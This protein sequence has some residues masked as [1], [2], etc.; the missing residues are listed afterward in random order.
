MF[1]F[2]SLSHLQTTILS[3]LITI[4]VCLKIGGTPYLW[5]CEIAESD[6]KR[7]GSPIS[8]FWETAHEGRPVHHAMNRFCWFVMD[9][10]FV[11]FFP[12]NHLHMGMGQIQG[13]FRDHYDVFGRDAPS[14][15]FLNVL[16]Q[17][18]PTWLRRVNVLLCI[19]V[20]KKMQMPRCQKPLG[21]KGACRRGSESVNLDPAAS[22][23]VLMINDWERNIGNNNSK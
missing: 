12:P 3:C 23:C 1:Y 10:W 7:W 16:A 9:L 14:Q 11:F 21:C 15:F 4:Q 20:P 19:S 13:A 17:T 8:Q 2:F 5:P 22:F 18:R 6:D